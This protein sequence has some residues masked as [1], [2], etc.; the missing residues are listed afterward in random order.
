MLKWCGRYDDVFTNFYS[1]LSTHS[2]FPFSSIFNVRTTPIDM[3][4]LLFSRLFFVIPPSSPVL[5]IFEFNLTE[6][7]SKYKILYCHDCFFK[8]YSFLL[9]SWFES[10]KSMVWSLEIKFLTQ[11]CTLYYTL[12]L[13]TIIR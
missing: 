3:L 1:F 9:M 6:E 8:V 13:V 10:K 2:H 11:Y 7:T 5:S 4:K 12:N